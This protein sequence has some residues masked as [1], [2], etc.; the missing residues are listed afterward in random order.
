MAIREFA[1]QSEGEKIDKILES[2]P[3]KEHN[4][5]LK[6][7]LNERGSYSPTIGNKL[8]IWDRA[9]EIGKDLHKLMM[10]AQGIDE[11]PVKPVINQRI[12][13]DKTTIIR[14]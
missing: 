9:L 7:V 6:E 2:F 11:D 12:G 8:P 13:R 3:K 5:I 10:K 1:N 4:A 14:Q